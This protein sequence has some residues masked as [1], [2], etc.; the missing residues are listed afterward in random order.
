M[1]NSTLL[2]VRGRLIKTITVSK[3]SLHACPVEPR[4]V[5]RA[6]AY[7][8]VL[9][10]CHPSGSAD[11][12]DSDVQ[13]TERLRAAGELVGIRVHDHIVIAADAYFSFVEA[14]RWRR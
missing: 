2:D 4:D 11:P 12:S 1:W 14:G 7:G 10:H 3:G 6:N 5:I 9:A 13:L 8:L